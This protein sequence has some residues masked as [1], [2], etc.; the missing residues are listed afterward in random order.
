MAGHTPKVLRSEGSISL[1]LLLHHHLFLVDLAQFTSPQLPKA[2][3]ER[4]FSEADTPGD[5]HRLNSYKVAEWAKRPWPSLEPVDSTSTPVM[6]ISEEAPSTSLEEPP[7]KVIRMN[8]IV[9]KNLDLDCL[10]IFLCM[11]LDCF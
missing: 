6:K 7:S 11:N 10:R 9:L 5:Y 3:V 4:I 2:Q 8:R 1:C